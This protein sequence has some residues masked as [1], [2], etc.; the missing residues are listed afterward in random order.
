MGTLHWEETGHLQ[1]STTSTNSSTLASSTE[2]LDFTYSDS[3]TYVVE[4]AHVYSLLGHLSG[5]ITLHPTQ[6]SLSEHVTWQSS[7][8]D[9]CYDG[10]NSCQKEI[11]NSF[12]LMLDGEAST[13]LPIPLVL[14]VDGKGASEYSM[15][16]TLPGYS[17]SSTGMKRT[18]TTE[19]SNPN[20]KTTSE[21]V[22]WYTRSDENTLTGAFE[23]A[24]QG[25]R[26]F[27]FNVTPTIRGPMTSPPPKVPTDISLDWDFAVPVDHP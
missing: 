8:I 11:G 14:V 23:G 13:T 4:S 5:T 22:T 10:S 26:G 21:S 20:D 17:V 9:S 6:L 12:T 18:W 25:H 7:G 19:P 3:R 2:S 1:K 16:V 27:T 24:F 15:D